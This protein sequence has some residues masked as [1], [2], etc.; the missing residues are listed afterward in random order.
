MTTLDSSIM[1]ITPNTCNGWQ[2]EVCGI[3]HGATEDESFASYEDALTHG[4]IILAELIRS[5]DD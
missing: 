2:V 5:L 1:M 4:Q 3:I